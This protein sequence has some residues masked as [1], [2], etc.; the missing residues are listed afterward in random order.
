MNRS[1]LRQQ[2][3]FAPKLVM[4]GDDGPVDIADQALAKNDVG[5]LPIATRTYI[6]QR[7]QT[8]NDRGRAAGLV[9]ERLVGEI[10]QFRNGFANGHQILQLVAMIPPYRPAHRMYTDLCDERRGRPHARSLK[11][12]SW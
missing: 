7:V 10:R 9:A 4:N 1:V 11:P 5:D 6:W 2:V 12:S 8:W 3:E